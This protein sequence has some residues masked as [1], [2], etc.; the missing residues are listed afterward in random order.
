M[1]I[2][3]FILLIIGIL[4]LYI[5]FVADDNQLMIETIDKRYNLPINIDP[6]FIRLFNGFVGIVETLCALYIILG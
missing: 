4:Q 3:A 5:T 1:I 6:N 2:L